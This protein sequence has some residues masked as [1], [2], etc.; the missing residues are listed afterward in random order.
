MIEISSGNQCL[1]FAFQKSRMSTK[2][3]NKVTSL[4]NIFSNAHSLPL[5]NFI[6][7]F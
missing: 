1:R 7:F 6:A 4:L 3:E 2:R 5:I